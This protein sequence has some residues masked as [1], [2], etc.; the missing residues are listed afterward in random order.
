M[1]TETRFWQNFC[2]AIDRNDLF[3][4]WPGRPHADHDYGN[5]ALREELEL[6]FATRTR[7]QWVE[8]F[9]EHDVAGAPVYVGGETHAD[10]HF[11]TRGLWLDPKTHGLRL[12]GP[13]LRIEGDTA[14]APRAAP[15]GGQHTDNV[16][17]NVLG[18]DDDRIAELRRSGA[19]GEPST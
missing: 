19:I 17:R 18:Y 12:V 2:R 14:V 4:R 7:A 16:L 3:E 9:I 10:P 6:I 11:A 1:A 5:V 8:L 13:P 15:S